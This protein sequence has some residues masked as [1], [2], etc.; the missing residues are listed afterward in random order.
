MYWSMK[1]R[2]WNYIERPFTWDPAACRAEMG[3]AGVS[4]RQLVDALGDDGYRYTYAKVML[5]GDG[6]RGPRNRAGVAAVARV[7]GC[8]V[9]DLVVR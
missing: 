1:T 7:L 9:R 5:T 6:G 8:R 4:L 3:R 2:H